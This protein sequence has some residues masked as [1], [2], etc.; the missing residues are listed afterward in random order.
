VALG[1][2]AA[3]TA[4]SFGKLIN[5]PPPEARPSPTPS[6]LPS[7]VPSRHGS[8]KTARAAASVAVVPGLTA[9]PPAPA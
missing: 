5:P 2:P 8:P 7:R 3:L 4:A 9:L 1:L 6:L